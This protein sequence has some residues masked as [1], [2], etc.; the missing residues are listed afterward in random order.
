MEVEQH[1]LVLIL[2]LEEG[3][4]DGLV[5]V[6]DVQVLPLVTRLVQ[7]EG[8]ATCVRGGIPSELSL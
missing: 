8:A 1:P 2:G 7:H 4:R 5:L 6:G 3:E